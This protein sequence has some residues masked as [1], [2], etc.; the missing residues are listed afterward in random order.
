MPEQISVR[1]RMYRHGLGDCILVTFKND[2]GNQGNQQLFHMLFDC[3][4]YKIT[5]DSEEK[6]QAV[7]QAIHAETN[8]HL[9]VVVITHEHWDHT[10]G[11]QQAQQLWSSFIIEE[12][13]L[14]WTEDPGI[15]LSRALHEERVRGVRNLTDFLKK[16]TPE[17]RRQIM[18]EQELGTVN[19]LLSSFGTMLEQ[20][21]AAIETT[22]AGDAINIIKKITKSASYHRP[23]TTITH[24]AL[25]GVRFHVLGPPQDGL[26]FKEGKDSKSGTIFEVGFQSAI[27]Q[28]LFAAP[29]LGMSDENEIERFMPFPSELR[30]LPA[31]V[32]E[33]NFYER[34]YYHNE[35]HWREI[36]TDWLRSSIGLALNLAADTNNT[37]L[38]LAIELVSSEKVLLFTGDAQV[39][40]WLSWQNLPWPE[41]SPRQS[42]DL[43]WSNDLLRRTVFYKVGHHGSENA[44]L[45][46]N[47]LRRMSKGELVAMIPLDMQLATTV[48]DTKKWPHPPLLKELLTYTG[49]RVIVADPTDTLPPTLPEGSEYQRDQ[50]L[51]IQKGTFTVT[52]THIDYIVQG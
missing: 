2:H 32:R 20:P 48:W 11:F 28:G 19:A 33:L 26:I 6:M 22:P 38:V 29:S 45:K 30:L 1:V 50:A 37:S 21:L 44:T 13:W 15:P 31:Q 35:Q 7:V 4:I 46:D 36:E 42:A 40:N 16:L 34:T 3:G 10:S 18:T 23:G 25:P 51:Q 5:R 9:D 49:G 41:G 43:S 52:N 47:G 17:Q 8:G 39:G 12:L 24:N 14:S 27:A